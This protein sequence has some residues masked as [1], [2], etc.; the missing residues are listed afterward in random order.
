MHFGAEEH[1]GVR[2]ESECDRLC[3]LTGEAFAL[4]DDGEFVCFA[5]GE[6]V[7]LLSF[8]GDLGG[9]QLLFGLA[10]E[11][12]AAAHRDR[13][14]DRLSKAG[15]DDQ[16]AGGMRGCPAGDDTERDEQTVLG[17]EH[18]LADAREPPDPRRLT[19]GMLLDVPRRFGAGSV[20]DLLIVGLGRGA[21]SAVARFSGQK[22]SRLRPTIPG[23]D[24]RVSLL[25]RSIAIVVSLGRKKLRPTLIT[26]IR[27]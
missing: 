4:E 23:Q 5:V 19:D 22:R 2:G 6:L 14:R 3:L 1:I 25:R 21:I 9:V 11:V 7:D 17:A 12:G 27:R 15:D 10:G 18:E 24:Q 20:V 26:M 8:R 13:P 16:R